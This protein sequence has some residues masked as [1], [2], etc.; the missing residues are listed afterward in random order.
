MNTKYLSA[1]ERRQLTIETVVT[2]AGVQNPSDITT[3]AIAER[4]HVTQGALFRH[5]PS[6]DAIWEAVMEWAADRLLDR[7]DQAADSASSPIDALRS[8]FLGHVDFVVA[9]PG[10]P[11]M[12]FGELQREKATPARKVVRNLLKRYAQRVTGKL[13]QAK[14]AGV[15]RSDTDIQAAATLFIGTIQGLV[16]QSMLSGNLQ[17]AKSNA[18][19]VLL[20]YLRGL[21]VD[22]DD[23]NPRHKTSRGT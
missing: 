15:V 18:P 4:M 22:L 7:I 9:H 3:A 21:G 13:E 2:L 19:G 14:A 20:I 10:V 8:M 23:R 6:K 17:V 5:F 16:M 11:R 12:L 1:S